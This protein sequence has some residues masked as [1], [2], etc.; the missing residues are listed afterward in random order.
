VDSIEAQRKALSDWLLLWRVDQSLG[1]AVEKPTDAVDSPTKE[2][3][4]LSHSDFTYSAAKETPAEGD[5]VLL[6]PI[7]RIT[8]SRP[9]YFALRKHEE[10]GW[11]AVPFARLPLPATDSEFATGRAE[12]PLRVLAPWNAGILS[13]DIL[14]QAWKVGRLRPV[15]LAALRAYE[16]GKTP[17]LKAG[18]PIVHPL[19]P[20]HNYLDEERE[21][22]VECSLDSSK[23]D[24]SNRPLEYP[25][26]AEDHDDDP[27][28][29]T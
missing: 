20:R 18:P 24:Y 11:L 25:D 21:L 6:P 9:V 5:V 13:D 2:N 4:E 22:W 1:N 8:Q 12:R 26:A 17:S 10:D 15:E 16:N 19:D 29:T 7:G 28:P 23:L 3:L 27:P 14:E